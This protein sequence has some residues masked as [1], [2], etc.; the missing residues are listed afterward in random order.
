ML[1]DSLQPAYRQQHSTETAF[2][3]V[4]HDIMEALDNQ[5]SAVMVLLDLSAAFDVI[6]HTILFQRLETT[7]GIHGKSLAWIKSYLT[8]RHQR[9]VIGSDTSDPC[10]L[11]FGVPQ[12]SVLGP[13]LY[14]LFSKPIG[15]ICRHHGFKYH[16]YADDTQVYMIIKTHENWNDY[17]LRLEKCLQDISNWMSNNLLKLNQDKTELIIFTTKF[18]SKNVPVLQL[19]VGESVINSVKS[20]RNLGIHFDSF[21]TMEKQVSYIIKTCNYHLRNIG[22][23]RGFISTDACKTLVN[24]LVTSRL[25]YGNSL[26][27]NINKGSMD[28]LQ[29]I[30]NTAARLVTKKENE[31]ISPLF[32]LTYIG[33]LLNSVRNIKFLFLPI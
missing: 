12:G 23:I 13:K 26:L 28:K 30:Q 18:Q 29:K 21:L 14:C 9:V 3:R 17:F 15:D 32:L 5:S 7:Y 10:H 33:F 20:V 22:R 16:C 27:F 31:I 19:K 2:L 1:R 8:N 4:S 25:D 24:S 11:Q 6:D